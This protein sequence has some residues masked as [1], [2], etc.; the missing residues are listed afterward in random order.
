[1]PARA[2][3]S[4][5][6]HTL[7]FLF[8]GQGSQQVGMGR[9]L[10]ESFPYARLLFEEADA[11]L[12][13]PLSTLC[14]DGPEA[15]LTRTQNT[16]PAILTVSV[17]AAEVLRRE[18]GLTPTL[19]AGHSLGE[20]SALVCAGALR[21][22]DAV[23]LVHLRGRFMQEAVPDGLGAMAAIV[24]LDPAAVA[25][26]CAEA[27]GE[28]GLCQPA[29]LNGAGQIVIS[30]HKTAVQRALPLCK[31]RG[32]KLTKLLPVSAPFHS[33]LMG[34]AA[35]RL[36]AE[37][38]QVPV[39]PPTQTVIANVD[40]APYPAGDAAA[41]RDRLYRQ[42]VGAVRWE[43]STA[44]LQRLGMTHAVEVGP[45]KVL[46]GLLKRTAPTVAQE[47]CSTP[48]DAARIGA[49]FFSGAAG[50]AA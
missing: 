19:L 43:E 31:S 30:G 25:A 13:Y 7:A 44:T 22:G 38:D 12:R 16:Q 23:R 21:F 18:A 33:V 32:A 11:A 8:P 27:S 26:A 37:L 42:V 41:V 40:A 49:G 34:P 39:S 17:A 5:M 35:D 6:S 36:R 48:E 24:G 3:E 9:L 50:P 47:A 4:N 46:G 1:M 2:M 15:D 10:C 20:Y 28:D 29:N 14:F 45:G